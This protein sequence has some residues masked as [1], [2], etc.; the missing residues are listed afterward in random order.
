MAVDNGRGFH[1]PVTGA[2]IPDTRAGRGGSN[3]L[4][5]TIGSYA[6]VGTLRTKLQTFS[7]TTYTDPILDKMTANDMIYAA[8]IIDGGVR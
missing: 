8:R 5:A 7:A 6:S 4:A 1:S 3:P 2:P